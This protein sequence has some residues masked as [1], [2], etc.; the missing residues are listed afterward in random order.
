MREHTS[1]P[2]ATGEHL[3]GKWEFRELIEGDLIDYARPDLC[4][5]G[6][7]TEAQEARRLVRDALR[8]HGA[9]Q[10][11]RAGLDGG[12]R[13]ALHRDPELR[14]ARALLAARAG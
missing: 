1:A 4:V 11:A 5:F 7:L 3:V 12:L 9:A 6:G 10:P 13:R 2:I 14:R 8:R